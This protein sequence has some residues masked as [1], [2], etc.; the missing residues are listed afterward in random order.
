MKRILLFVGTNIAVLVVLSIVTSLL[1]VDRWITQQGINPVALLAFAAVF[2]FGGAFISLAIS[3]RMA[4]WTTGAQ[5]IQQPSNESEAWLVS[6]VGQ[7]ARQSGIGQPDVAIYP[8]TELNA[9]ATGMR[10]DKA[11][12][13]VSQ[14][15]LQGMRRE[16]VEAVLAHEVSHVANGDMVTMTLLQG[17]LNTFVI[18]V[19]RVVGWAVGRFAAGEDEEGGGISYLAYIVTTIAAQILLGIGA[20]LIVMAFSRH[21]EF[22]A[23]AGAAQLV[24]AGGMVAALKRLGAQSDEASE[25]PEPVEAF[26]IRGGKSWMKLF[27]SHPPLEQRIAALQSR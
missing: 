9:F 10:R 18:A 5:I 13:A 16:E 20:S 6:T 24:G 8:G 25:L 7:L 17:V 3:K 27:A 4:L 19:S 21:R 11:L 12:V 22:R 2:G 26:G 23:D 1:G 15:L 14:G